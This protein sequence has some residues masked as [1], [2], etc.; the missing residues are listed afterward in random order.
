MAAAQTETCGQ[1]QGPSAAQL[2]EGSPWQA[3]PL[4]AGRVSQGPQ[5]AAGPEELIYV[6]AVV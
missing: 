1:R 6:N 4:P 3:V 2:W 5:G